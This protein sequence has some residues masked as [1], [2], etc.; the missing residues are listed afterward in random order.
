MTWETFPCC[1]GNQCCPCNPLYG[2]NT[3]YR[4]TWNGSFSVDTN[5]D[6]DCVCL[7]AA[8]SGFGA[9]AEMYVGAGFNV[10]NRSYVSSYVNS[11]NP[12][13]PN[14]CLMTSYQDQNM[15]RIVSQRWF[16]DQGICGPFPG[17]A[18]TL[19][20]KIQLRMELYPPQ[21][22]N[23][24]G[25]VT[26]AGGGGPFIRPWKVRVLW[27]SLVGLTFDGGTDCIPGPFTLNLAESQAGGVFLV[28]PYG[29][30]PC[31]AIGQV[32]AGTV[33]Y[34]AGSVTVK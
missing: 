6:C 32:A 27:A 5:L 4:V 2:G 24:P 26:I 34:L 15:P 11:T 19:G 29:N 14:F 30:L 13:D 33:T 16:C 25:C 23:A 20:P 3:S 17:A 28:N 31:A 1:C 21:R 22:F 7:A 9:A 8:A 10:T 18:R 12:T